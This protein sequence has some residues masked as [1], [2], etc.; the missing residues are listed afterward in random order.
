MTVSKVSSLGRHFSGVVVVIQCTRRRL[1]RFSPPLAGRAGFSF[2]SPREGGALFHS[3]EGKIDTYR[4]ISRAKPPVQFTTRLHEVN[5][6]ESLFYFLVY[7][8]FSP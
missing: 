3:V 4:R 6:T 2:T 7:G 1:Q 8:N 5:T